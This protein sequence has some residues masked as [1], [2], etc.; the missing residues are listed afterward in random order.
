MLHQLLWHTV[1]GL[2]WHYRFLASSP[3]PIK[4]IV[5]L[6]SDGSASVTSSVSAVSA[7]FMEQ[8]TYFLKHE[9][10]NLTDRHPIDLFAINAFSEHLSVTVRELDNYWHALLF[11]Q[12]ELQRDEEC[13]D[14]PEEDCDIR[15]RFWPDLTLLEPVFDY[16]ATLELMR[17]FTDNDPNVT[18]TVIDARLFV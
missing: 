8:S 11:E 5:S 1:D 13:T 7:V 4:I 2:L 14:P 17:S 18:I 10:S 16:Q 9:L 12:G 3:Q 15:L 6:E